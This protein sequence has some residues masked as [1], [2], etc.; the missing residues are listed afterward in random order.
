MVAAMAGVYK[1]AQKSPSVAGKLWVGGIGAGAV[2]IATKNISNNLSIDIGK[3]NL[4]SNS[5]LMDTL[6][7]MLNL[8][9]NNAL[10][11][12][13]LI[14]HFQRLQLFFIFFLFLITYYFL[15]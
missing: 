7:D 9:G 10:D 3:T 14:Q 2:V 11:L 5:N 6:K 15:N 1:L 12:L 4:I 13:N 8:T